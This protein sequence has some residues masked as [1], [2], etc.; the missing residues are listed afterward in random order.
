MLRQPQASLGFT[1]GMGHPFSDHRRSRK[2]ARATVAP[3]GSMKRNAPL[4]GVYLLPG[5]DPL[6]PVVSQSTQTKQLILLR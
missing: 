6:A 4:L 2:L 5:S 1:K 3:K